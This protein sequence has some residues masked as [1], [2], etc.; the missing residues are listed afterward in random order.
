MHHEH[1]YTHTHINSHT[2][3][4]FKVGSVLKLIPKYLKLLHHP[5]VPLPRCLSLTLDLKLGSILTHI[6]LLQ[7]NVVSDHSYTCTR[8]NPY[9]DADNSTIPFAYKMKLRNIIYTTSKP[10]DSQSYH[11]H[12]NEHVGQSWRYYTTLTHA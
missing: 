6:D 2:S 3:T 8:R 5:I 9:T 7:L 4:I 12:N 11:K 1:T 10:T